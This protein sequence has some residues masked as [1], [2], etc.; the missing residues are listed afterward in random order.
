M[1]KE[2][3]QRIIREEIARELANDNLLM[4]ETYDLEQVKYSASIQ[5]QVDSL[6]SS[7]QKSSN[8]SK[9]Q[10]AAILNDNIMAMGLN[11]TQMTL[12]MN[13]IKQNRQKYSF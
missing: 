12:Y 8:L 7:L 1:K 13:M 3:L 4:T 11:R 6:V 2:Q 9:V 10:V 5:K